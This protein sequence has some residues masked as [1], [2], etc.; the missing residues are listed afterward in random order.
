MIKKFLAEGLSKSVIARKLGVS[1]DTVRRYA[2][3]LM[4]LYS[5]YQ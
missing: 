5:P 1:R 3:F 2:I 4:R